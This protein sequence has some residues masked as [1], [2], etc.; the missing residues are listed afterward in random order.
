MAFW[1]RKPRIIKPI[2][3]VPPTPEPGRHGLA[4]VAMMRNEARYIA[5][6]VEFHRLAGV[7]HFFIYD[8][9][10]TDGSAAAFRNAT[11]PDEL[12]LFPWNMEVSDMKR[13]LPIDVQ[14]LATAHAISNFGGRF[15]WMAALDLDE[16][17]FPVKENSLLDAL[18][19]LEHVSNISLPWAHFGR[20]GHQTRPAGGIVRNY[21]RRCRDPMT[22]LNFKCIIDPCKV[23]GAA[24]HYF[25][26]TD[27]GRSTA[28][29]TG[30]ISSRSHRNEGK[31]ISYHSIQLNHYYSKSDEEL[32]EKLMRGS[33]SPH[34]RATYTSL[35]TEKV[36]RIEEDT[37]D[38]MRAIEFLT[39]SASRQQVEGQGR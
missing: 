5:E 31:N 15:R 4:L 37:V 35:V 18:A 6:W 33:A 14:V 20:C 30:D 34:Q 23:T 19:D 1:K 12:T 24:L 2:G 7:E 26:T 22:E 39:R 9:G 36:R 3:I 13:D 16:F 29:D 10:S 28:N 17:L 11:S 38:D 21:T 27:L 25:T 32:R 8:N